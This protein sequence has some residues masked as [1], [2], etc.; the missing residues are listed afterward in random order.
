MSI[1]KEQKRA[2][3]MMHVC[4]IF[5]FMSVLFT[6]WTLFDKTYY[7]T[8]FGVFIAACQYYNYKLWQKKA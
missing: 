4:V 8:V 2:R 5:G 3:F 6:I 1:T 7:M